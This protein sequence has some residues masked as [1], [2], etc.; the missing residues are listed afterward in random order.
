MV[1]VQLSSDGNP[2]YFEV[3]LKVMKNSQASVIEIPALN[4][5][6]I[7]CFRDGNAGRPQI[8]FVDRVLKFL[9][10]CNSIVFNNGSNGGLVNV[11]D[12]VKAYN[13]SQDDVNNLKNLI[14]S[15]VPVSGDGGASLKTTL[16]TW[17]GTPLHKT[18]RKDIED[19]KVT[20]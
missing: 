5:N 1:D 7:I 18:V 12:V 15:W 6:C 3:P 13:A 2:T 16:A 11:V 4:S 14:G 8:L 17:T 19:T 9:V 20:H 10:N